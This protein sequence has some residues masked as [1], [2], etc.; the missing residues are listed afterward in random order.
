LYLKVFCAL[1]ADSNSYTNR[2]QIWWFCPTPTKFA[3][4]NSDSGNLPVIL[5]YLIGLVKFMELVWI[6]H[7]KKLEFHRFPCT[8]KFNFWG[9]SFTFE[10]WRLFLRKVLLQEVVLNFHDYAAKNFKFKYHVCSLIFMNETPHWLDCEFEEWCGG[11]L[12]GVCL[13]GMNMFLQNFKL[14]LAFNYS[15]VYFS[16]D[17]ICWC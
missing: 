17:L 9:I 6:S 13:C 1:F 12:G 8:I 15:C 3:V 16:I 11:W 10:A 4:D 7:L 5:N 2:D 14:F